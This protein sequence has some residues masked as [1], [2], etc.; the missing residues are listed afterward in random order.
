[1]EGG[2]M[3]L[4]SQAEDFFD[5]GI[6]KLVPRYDKFFNSGGAYVEM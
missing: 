4:S 1:M 5:T 3:W 6:Q 2:K